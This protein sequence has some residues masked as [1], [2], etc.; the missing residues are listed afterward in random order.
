M[1]TIEMSNYLFFRTDRIGDFL[2]SAI[3][4]NSIKRNDLNSNITV[5]S[6]KNNHLY[7]KSLNFI[8]EV[9]LYPDNLI[10]KIT[11]FLKLNKKKYNLIGALDGKKRSIYFSILLKS[12][13]KVLMT[14]KVFFTKILKKKFS[15]I[16]LFEETKN[17]LDEIIEVLNLCNMSFEK[18]DLFFLENQKILSNKIKCIPNYL[19]LHFDEKWIFNDYIRKYVSIEPNHDEFNLFIQEIIK[20]FNLNLVVTTGLKENMI[21]NKFKKDL[22]KINE[23]LYE[24]EYNNKKIQLYTNLDFFDLEFLIKNCNFL[25]TCHGASTHVA[26][27]FNKKIYDIFDTSQE[28]FYKKWNSHI[29]NYKYFYREKFRSLTKKILTKK[30]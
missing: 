22:N 8:D 4:I 3:L 21:I 16:F 14:T 12:K 17:K 10:D 18:K 6:S 27:A 29:N 28:K 24:K 13:T 2:V 15:K 26:S 23:N 1:T 5:V 30:I 20:N 11:L 25:I 7:I 19:I 9:Y